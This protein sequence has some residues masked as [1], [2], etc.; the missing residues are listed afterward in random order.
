MS[1]PDY[2]EQRTTLLTQMNQGLPSLDGRRVLKPTYELKEMRSIHREI[3]R[4][5]V[6]GLKQT[7]IAEALNIHKQ[8]VS[9]VSNNPIVMRQIKM[10]QEAK[11]ANAAK[12]TAL[13]DLRPDAITALEELV[14]DNDEKAKAVRLSAARDILDRTDGKP[15]QRVETQQTSVILAHIQQLKAKARNIGVLPTKKNEQ[16]EVEDAQVIE[17]KEQPIVKGPAEEDSDS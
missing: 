1:L 10:L 11:D 7:E 14:N 8:T 16:E 9:N 4:L 3:V 5:L 12:P 2:I 17:E 6:A 15:V 13:D